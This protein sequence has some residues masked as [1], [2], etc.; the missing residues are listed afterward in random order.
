MKC[1]SRHVKRDNFL[2]VTRIKKTIKIKP[3]IVLDYS[4]LI[5]NICQTISLTETNKR[6]NLKKER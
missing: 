2:R 3:L 5:Y 4:V 1:F 6:R